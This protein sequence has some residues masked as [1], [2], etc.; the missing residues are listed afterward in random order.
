MS[1]GSI[2]LGLLARYMVLKNICKRAAREQE[3]ARI[4]ESAN[5]QESV[6]FVARINNEFNMRNILLDFK[7]WQIWRLFVALVLLM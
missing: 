1:Y 7:M 3:S 6:G 4:L 2:L 5:L